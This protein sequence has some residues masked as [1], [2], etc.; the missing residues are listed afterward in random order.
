VW[1]GESSPSCLLKGGMISEWVKSYPSS[2]FPPG[3]RSAGGLLFVLLPSFPTLPLLTARKRLRGLPPLP[4]YQNVPET[5]LPI[6]H[7]MLLANGDGGTY[8]PPF[9]I[10]PTITTECSP[11]LM[12]NSHGSNLPP[13]SSLPAGPRLHHPCSIP[14]FLQ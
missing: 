9:W 8:T 14:F 4:L 12:V 1:L 2:P 6:P 10:T 3:R 13:F 11:P 5:T 7:L